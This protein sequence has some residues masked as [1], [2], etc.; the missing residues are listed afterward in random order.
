MFHIIIKSSVC[1]DVSTLCESSNQNSPSAL[2]TSPSS[3]PPMSCTTSFVA[4]H[5]NLDLSSLWVYSYLSLKFFVEFEDSSLWDVMLPRWM[6][7]SWCFKWTYCLHC[8]GS[9]GPDPLDTVPHPRRPKSIITPLWKPQN[10]HCWISSH[11][12]P[13]VRLKVSCEYVWNAVA[14][15][16][17]AVACS[18]ENVLQCLQ[19]RQVMKRI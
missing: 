12:I 17:H 15:S 1:L 2:L 7:G 19:L 9:S 6:S 3:C 11:G 4:F 16:H 8:Q 13:C 18:V 10:F 5:T 14:V